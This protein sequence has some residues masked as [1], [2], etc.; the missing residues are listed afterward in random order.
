MLAQEARDI[1]L[2]ITNTRAKLGVKDGVMGA[3]ANAPLDFIG[4]FVFIG[5]KGDARLRALGSGAD[6]F[7]VVVRKRVKKD[8][9]DCLKDGA[10]ACAVVPDNGIDPWAKADFGMVIALNVFQFNR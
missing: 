9:T 1:R 5:D 8:K 10:F 2:A 3:A 6:K 4:A 7:I